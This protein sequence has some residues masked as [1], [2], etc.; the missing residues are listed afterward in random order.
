MEVI[1]AHRNRKNRDETK[2]YTMAQMLSAVRKER[3]LFS[4]ALELV[5]GLKK[6]CKE[7]HHPNFRAQCSICKMVKDFD[8]KIE[9]VRN[10]QL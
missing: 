4:F 9:Q 5:E 10:K 2:V 1:V 8:G 7:S 3:Q 6:L